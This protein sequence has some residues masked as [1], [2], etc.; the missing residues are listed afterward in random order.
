MP[1]AS[2]EVAD[3]ASSR[4]SGHDGT[5]P[6]HASLSREEHDR[7]ADSVGIN[8]S[9]LGGS[10]DDRD[11]PTGLLRRTSSYMGAVQAAAALQ[12]ETEA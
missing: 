9:N 4:P 5:V 12:D 11:D 10:T 3:H 2:T 1:T 8:T 6:V 7:G